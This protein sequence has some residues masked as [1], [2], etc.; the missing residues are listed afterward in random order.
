MVDQALSRIT[1][2]SVRCA[3]EALRRGDTMEAMVMMATYP[4]LSALCSIDP[5]DIDVDEPVGV[6]DSPYIT[7]GEI[8][9]LRERCYEIVTD[10]EHRYQ[11]I[12]DSFGVPPAAI[13]INHCSLDEWAARVDGLVEEVRHA[14]RERGD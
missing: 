5:G 6:P 2:E 4:P 1:V 10:R 14:G 11:M 7:A 12:A 13:D 8:Q 3:V 9:A